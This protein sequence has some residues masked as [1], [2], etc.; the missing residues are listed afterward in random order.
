MPRDDSG[1]VRIVAADRIQ[2]GI[3]A[4]RLHPEN[5][6]RQ[7]G[8]QLFLLRFGKNGDGTHEEPV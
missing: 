5:Q 1:R 8:D 2:N 7:Q 4:V 6:L 3:E